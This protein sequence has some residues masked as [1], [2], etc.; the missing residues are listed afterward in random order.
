MVSLRSFEINV[1]CKTVNY[2][3][4][5]EIYQDV[6]C[7]VRWPFSPYVRPPLCVRARACN[8]TPYVQC[9]DVYVVSST[10]KKRSMDDDNHGNGEC[11]TSA[12]KVCVV[13]LVTQQLL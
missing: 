12:W 1:T 7:S 9:L 3:T 4:R 8:Y 5:K 6:A 2:F 10:G 11:V 13:L